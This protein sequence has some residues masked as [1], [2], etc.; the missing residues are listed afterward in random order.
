MKL[1][2]KKL[3]IFV[4]YFIGCSS[5]DYC[6]KIECNSSNEEILNNLTTILLSENF[7]IIESNTTL[8]LLVP[9][10]LHK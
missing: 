8:G 6:I 2:M 7:N 5:S 9:K 3:I 10:K 1:Y 4:I